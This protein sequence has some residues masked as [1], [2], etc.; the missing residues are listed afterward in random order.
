LDAGMLVL[1]RVLRM[2]E[3]AAICKKHGVT[4]MM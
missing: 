2:P 1:A 3:A 4:V